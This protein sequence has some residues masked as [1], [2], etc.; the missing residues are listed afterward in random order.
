VQ[1]TLRML[2][3]PCDATDT[4]GLPLTEVLR[5]LVW[6]CAS[7]ITHGAENVALPII[8]ASARLL[9]PHLLL[10]TL[11]YWADPSLTEKDIRM[12][13]AS[14]FHEFVVKNE[15]SGYEEEARGTLPKLSSPCMLLCMRMVIIDSL[16]TVSFSAAE[17][18]WLAQRLEAYLRLPP[19]P[20]V[21]AVPDTFERTRR[22]EGA[23]LELETAC[24]WS[25]PGAS[26]PMLVSNAPLMPC[27][28]LGPHG[29]HMQP[30]DGPGMLLVDPSWLIPRPYTSCRPPLPPA[31]EGE[32]SGRLLGVKEIDT[33]ILEFLPPR[34]LRTAEQVCLGLARAV[35]DDPVLRWRVRMA[36]L[37]RQSFNRFYGEEW[38]DHDVRLDYLMFRLRR[39]RPRIWPVIDRRRT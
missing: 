7:S 12:Y 18:E 9:L 6:S 36:A 31:P 27:C 5:A 39:C 37:V 20:H 19:C 16:I 4:R 17:R 10:R 28:C 35:H 8:N 3:L 30:A 34:D 24:T 11:R 1:Q 14:A 22:P 33:I 38:G 15:G 26:V 2:G 32:E 21:S 25:V 13:L 23:S 29:A